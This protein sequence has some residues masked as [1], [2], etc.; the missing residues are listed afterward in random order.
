MISCKKKT[1]QLDDRALVKNKWS[2]LKTE[3]NSNGN[4]GCV[5]ALRMTLS[6]TGC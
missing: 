3:V 4:M 1:D 5:R 6:A 2:K